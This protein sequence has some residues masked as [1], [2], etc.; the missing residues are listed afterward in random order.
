MRSIIAKAGRRQGCRE[1]AFPRRGD[2]SKTALRIV[3][4]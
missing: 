4:K 1:L 3:L 2:I